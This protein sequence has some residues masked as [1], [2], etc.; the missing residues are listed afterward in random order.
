[1]KILCRLLAGALLL[2]GAEQI[3]FEDVGAKAGLKDVISS[4]GAKKNYVLEVNGSGACWLDY[5]GDGWMDLYLVNGS[6]IEQLQGKQPAR[7]TNHLYRNGGDGSFTDMT[8]KAGVPGKGWGFGCV[9]AD[10]DNDGHTDLYVT[11]FGENILYRNRGDGSFEDVTKKAGVAGSRIWHAGATFGDYDLDGDLDLFV[12]GY[13]DFDSAKPELKTCEYRG[14]K[15]NACG[16]LG[17]RGAPDTLFRNNGDGTFTDV[18]AQAGV[19]D[20]KLYFG[21]Q[22]ILEDFDNDGWPDL[23]VANDSHPNLLYKNNHDGSF[24]EIGVPA[25]VAYNADGKEM[26]SMGVAIGDYNRDGNTDIFITT[27]SNDNY[28]LFQNE[29]DG[30]FTDVSFAA[31]V[32]EPTIPYLGWA[33]F[34]LDYDNDGWL[35]LL[36]AN[37]HVYPEVDGVLQESYRQPLQLF[38]NLKNGRFRDVSKDAGLLAMARHS[39]RGGAYADIDNDGD[40]D[41]VISNMDA[42]PSLVENRGVNRGNWLRVV[43]E[44]KTSNRMAIGAKVKVIAEQEVRYG[45]LRAGDSYLSSSDPRL[46][47]G[48]GKAKSATVEVQ[49]PGGKVERVTGIAANQAVY[50]RQGEGRIAAPQK[51][52]R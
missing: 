46:H 40:L 9:A 36:C 22:A 26:S 33:S 16:P 48:L 39:A 35:D 43:L 18:T 27:F 25:G 51:T 24:T 2:A 5:D 19:A 21:F 13:L 47:F 7:T 30:L 52:S 28:V 6:T 3:Q 37:G 49:W 45:S 41:F 42:K 12:P 10:Y 34:F 11:N 8:L 38:H 15:V 50:I 31:G 29:G 1:M 32:G 4:G 14:L 17:Y 23:F 20:K 44:G